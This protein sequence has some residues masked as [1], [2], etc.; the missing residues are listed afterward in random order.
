MRIFRQDLNDPS[1]IIVTFN[2]HTN[3]IETETACQWQI[4]NKRPLTCQ[5]LIDSAQYL[6]EKGLCILKNK[7]F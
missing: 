2:F 6:N 3:F 1:M 7:F 4:C 5:L